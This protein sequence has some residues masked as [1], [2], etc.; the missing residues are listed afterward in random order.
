MMLT[1]GQSASSPRRSASIPQTCSA[2]HQRA[3]VAATASRVHGRAH[4]RARL[5]GRRA[6]CSHATARNSYADTA[7]ARS[8]THGRGQSR[9]DDTTSRNRAA[10]CRLQPP[11]RPRRGRQVLLAQAVRARPLSTPR[12]NPSNRPSC[13]LAQPWLRFTAMVRRPPPRSSLSAVVTTASTG[14]PPRPTSSAR[15]T[16]CPARRPDTRRNAHRR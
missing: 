7:Y 10:R 2:N 6:G 5:H 15:T 14:R 16:Q 8:R 9:A 3:N 13:P 11:Y 4:V 12:L 1:R